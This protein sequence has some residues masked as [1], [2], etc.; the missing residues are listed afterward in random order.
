MI[1]LKFELVWSLFCL[2]KSVFILILLCTTTLFRRLWPFGYSIFCKIFE[3]SIKQW[4]WS[5]FGL[6]KA[7]AY[8]NRSG[9]IFLL[10]SIR[11]FFSIFM[12]SDI[13][14]F[15]GVGR[16]TWRCNFSQSNLITFS[17]AYRWGIFWFLSAYGEKS[18]LKYIP[19]KNSSGISFGVVKYDFSTYVWTFPVIGCICV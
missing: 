17:F 4:A 19:W 1:H 3:S 2:R 18:C 8:K 11:T 9:S 10:T 14:T 16:E 5:F 13:Q 7:S 15:L 12:Y 6:N